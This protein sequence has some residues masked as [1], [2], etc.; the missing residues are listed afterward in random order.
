MPYCPKL[1]ERETPTTPSR[2]EYIQYQKVLMRCTTA[3]GLTDL[4]NWRNLVCKTSHERHAYSRIRKD[5]EANL[6]PI[7]IWRE[8]A[9]YDCVQMCHHSAAID[10][11]HACMNMRQVCSH[12]ADISGVY[13]ITHDM[14][15][16]ARHPKTC[17]YWKEPLGMST[18]VHNNLYM[19][20]ENFHPSTFPCSALHVSYMLC[21][22]PQFHQQ[23]HTWRLPSAVA[24]SI[25]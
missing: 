11:L 6:P 22:Q 1:P 15:F 20:H 24:V 17:F 4:T 2:L 8:F 3:T 16:I 13:I 7:S 14:T 23:V 18:G 5:T 19:W 25:Y 21:T 12:D 10:T 9:K